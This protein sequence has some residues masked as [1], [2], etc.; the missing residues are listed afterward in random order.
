VRP[1]LNNVK[2]EF[3]N[4]KQEQPEHGFNFQMYLNTLNDFS[5]LNIA[6]REPGRTQANY[7]R[8]RQNRQKIPLPG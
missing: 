1:V 8:C 3:R 2:A 4:C 7:N 6:H 5:R